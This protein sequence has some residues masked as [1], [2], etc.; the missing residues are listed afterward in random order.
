MGSGRETIEMTEERNARGSE[1]SHRPDTE[2]TASFKKGRNDDDLDLVDLGIAVL[3]R[4]RLILVVFLV[5]MALGIIKT[6]LAV[7]RYSYSTV[8]EM[9][10]WVNEE[11]RSIS[12][13]GAASA[14]AKLT[15][16]YI[17]HAT[18]QV[19]RSKGFP[20]RH[21]RVTVTTE[22]KGRR[23]RTITLTGKG[24]LAKESAYNQIET[25]AANE[26]IRDSKDYIGRLRQAARKMDGAAIDAPRRRST[27]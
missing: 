17:P 10:S 13:E 3:R 16:A 2:E 15:N 25:L 23:V 14:T 8:I 9:S 24:P 18:R 7:P 1:T 12:I 21:L 19:A 22:T 6:I 20:A 27:F 5:V 11:G 26:L 4:W